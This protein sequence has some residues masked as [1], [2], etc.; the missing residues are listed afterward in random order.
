MKKGISLA[1]MGIIMII[2]TIIT[3]VVV[4]N[5]KNYVDEVKK[6]KFVT[7]YML[8]ESA[9]K[10]YYDNNE[11]YPTKNENNKE[12]TIILYADSEAEETQF[13][14]KLSAAS[15]GISLKVVDVSLLGYDE[16]TTG[17]GSSEL[18]YYGISDDGDVY[19]VH[20]FKYK[21]KV[22]YKVVDDLK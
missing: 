9:V 5:S 8:V 10:K 1:T 6:S 4:I 13:G 20:G 14:D 21:D 22:Y 18:D 11:V 2:I 3:S 17:I 7:D 16:I 15:S 19:Y 12:K